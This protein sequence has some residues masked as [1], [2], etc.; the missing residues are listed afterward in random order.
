M[1][2]QIIG[3]GMM[4]LALAVEL[5]RKYPLISITL[6]EDPLSCGASQVASGLIHSF[7]GPRMRKTAWAALG[8]DLFKKQAHQLSEELNLD[9]KSI[10][11]EKTLLRPF[12]KKEQ[13][14]QKEQ[15]LTAEKNQ[16]FAIADLNKLLA[17]CYPDL[18]DK[19]SV[20]PLGEALQSSCLVVNTPF[21]LG[22]MRSFLKKQGAHFIQKRVCPSLLQQNQK[23]HPNDPSSFLF[24]CTGAQIQSSVLQAMYAQKN[25]TAIH[26]H[27]K[28]QSKQLYHTTGEILQWHG[29]AHPFLQKYALNSRYYYSIIPSKD[30]GIYRHIF[31]STFVREALSPGKED[32]LF[33]E[34]KKLEELALDKSQ[35]FTT[36]HD[37]T[38]GQKFTLL[39]GARSHTHSHLPEI[40]ALGM[41]SVGVAGLGSKGLLSHLLIAKKLAG[42]LPELPCQLV[43]CKDQKILEELLSTKHLFSL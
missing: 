42:L 39:G 27:L 41:R 24:V 7:H 35:F 29:P 26:E 34:R 31:G 12:W 19:E 30:P 1:D 18:A 43:A 8:K 37:C 5:K 21:Y 11:T 17:S 20:F 4:G 2:V 28:D 22:A 40:L 32:K 16:D 3:T 38:A 33:S 6:Y 14:K 23:S 36:S 9:A 25:H 13:K 15:L 10:Y